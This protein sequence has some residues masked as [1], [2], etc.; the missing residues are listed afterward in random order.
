MDRKQKDTS[1]TIPKK[2]DVV[3]ENYKKM[4]K[5][6]FCFAPILNDDLSKSGKTNMGAF[7]NIAEDNAERTL[8]YVLMKANISNSYST[9]RER[10]QPFIRRKKPEEL[11][12]EKGMK[13]MT[14]LFHHFPMLAPIIGI[15]KNKQKDINADNIINCLQKLYGILMALH[16][17]R[18]YYSHYDAYNSAD[19]QKANFKSYAKVAKDLTSVLEVSATICKKQASN[20]DKVQYEFFTGKYHY[21][22]SKGGKEFE[23]YYYRIY[24]KRQIVKADGTIN[25]DKVFFDALSDFGIVYLVSLFL[26]MSDRDLMLERLDIFKDSPFKNVKNKDGQPRFSH[27]EEI[28]K[29]IMSVYRINM[30]K[31]KKLMMEDDD[32]QI[33]MDM[34]NELH[35]CPKELYDLLTN[36]MQNKFKRE[37]TEVIRDAKTGEIRRFKFVRSETNDERQTAVWSTDGTGNIAYRGTGKYS[38][39]KRSED[40]FPYFALRF[41]DNQGWFETIRFQIDLG[42]YRFAFYTKHDKIFGKPDLRILQKHVNGFGK[43]VETETERLRLWGDHFQDYEMKL[44]N[45]NEENREQDEDSD[46][47]QQELVQLKESD[48]NTDPFVTDKRVSYNLNNN[49]VELYWPD[50]DN[51]FMHVPELRTKE[52]PD[53]RTADKTRPDLTTY[54][55]KASLS[56]RDLPALIFYEYLRRTEHRMDDTISAEQIIKNTYDKYIACFTGIANGEIKTWQQVKD[57]GIARRDMPNRLWEYLDKNG[58]V[59]CLSINEMVADL[60]EGKD[61]INRKDKYHYIGHLEERI[62]RTKYIIECIESDSKKIGTEDNAYGTEDYADLRP[63]VLARRLSKSIMEWLPSDCPGKKIMTGVNYNTMTSAFASYGSKEGSPCIV[64]SQIKEMLIKGGILGNSEVDGKKRNHLFLADVLK[65]A[66][67]SNILTLS[68][69]YFRKELTF[70]KYV[71]AELSTRKKTKKK[72]I[73]EMLPFSHL[74]RKR[75]QNRDAQYYRDLA[76]SYLRIDNSMY[77]GAKDS[78]SVILLPDGLFSR[79]ISRLLKDMHTDVFPKSM[80]EAKLRNASYLIVTYF[81]K[82]MNDE[83]QMFYHYDDYKRHYE[84]FDM[85]DDPKLTQKKK[86]NSQP[87]Q[88]GPRHLSPDIIR[89]RLKTDVTPQRIQQVIKGFERLAQINIDLYSK[90]K[91]KCY[92]QLTELEEHEKKGER[93]YP[94]LYTDKKGRKQTQNIKVK[95]ERDRLEKKI[96]KVLSRL[97]KAKRRKA[98]IK[99]IILR[100]RNMCE[101]T[102]RTIRRYRVEDI[103]TSMMIRTFFD[104]KFDREKQPE[105]PTFSLVNVG[106]EKPKPAPLPKLNDGRKVF[107]IDNEQESGERYLDT[108]VSLDKKIEVNIELPKREELTDSSTN[109]IFGTHLSEEDNSTECLNRPRWEKIFSKML[110]TGENSLQFIVHVHHEGV[111]LRNY[112]I[113]LSELNDERL[114]KFL[115]QCVFLEFIENSERYETPE[116]RQIEISFSRLSFEFDQYNKLRPDIFAQVHAIEHMILEKYGE[117]RD[118]NQENSKLLKR[119]NFN[120]LINLAYNDK[121]SYITGMMIEIRNS[122]CHNHYN[123]CTYMSFEDLSLQKKSYS[124]NEEEDINVEEDVYRLLRTFLLPQQETS[125]SGTFADLI[126]NKMKS[127]REAVREYLLQE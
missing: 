102:E 127:L 66:S 90:E 88:E 111:A 55:P 98:E 56:T 112:N 64:L 36:K 6:T 50:D 5:H 60:Y 29:S 2:I 35:K 105:I 4:A 22:E 120:K 3:F 23:D 58:R 95:D 14:L 70:L 85:L 123:D 11:S 10:I 115:Q 109:N 117:L 46:S 54:T 125:M 30:P 116:S 1:D 74:S 15:E 119:N 77:D 104:A 63:G 94:R 57:L 28:M 103:V 114:E 67:I 42:Y 126:L 113:M 27:E 49:R 53:S 31:G 122:A 45:Q 106:K 48:E 78:P 118:P 40:R 39:L 21:D 82:V 62:A 65:S 25:E 12:I 68:L 69:E 51:D 38:L 9:C 124:N 83:S 8:Q 100:A 44:P 71:K 92:R 13:L 17:C 84:L 41:I 33:C 7:V 59:E 16:A 24:G 80:E 19:K 93:S 87:E 61:V 73:D 101:N 96:P 32:V 52:N 108:I 47:Q 43:L 26:R 72:F 107:Y 91:E 37:R 20:N 79:Y 86:K 99:D 110:E 97:E 18:N 89:T 76:K 75:M 34:V 121:R 81:E